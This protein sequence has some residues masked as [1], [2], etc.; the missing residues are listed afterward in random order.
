METWVLVIWAYYSM[1][2]IPGYTWQ[3]CTDA[4]ARLKA[5]VERQGS[6]DARAFCV[7]GPKRAP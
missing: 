6:I 2:A 7:L 3:E 5:Q 1:V 4:V